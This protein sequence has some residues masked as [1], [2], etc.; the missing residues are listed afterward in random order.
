MDKISIV[1]VCY[2][3]QD[4]IR[5][6][7]DSVLA[8]TYPHIEYVL[9]DGGSTDNTSKIVRQ[10]LEKFEEKGIDNILL[11]GSDQGIYDAMNIAIDA[12]T[13]EWILFLNAGDTFYNQYVLEEI[14]TGFSYKATVL[15]GNL[16]VGLSFGRTFITK[17]NH[18][19]LLDY[20]SVQHQ[21]SFIKTSVLK[22]FKYDT[23]YEICADYELFVKLLYNKYEFKYINK[24]ISEFKMGGASSK[25]FDLVDNERNR[26][27]I[28]YNKNHAKIVN[29]HNLLW[30]I[31]SSLRNKIPIIGEIALIKK[32]LIRSN[33][34]E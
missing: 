14:F 29:S 8:Q 19:D 16:I 31:K 32:E 26:I 18:N 6:T 9:K 15:Y 4:V 23:S 27:K 25:H 20:I 17:A 3:A 28:T 11:E 12:C 21:A 10:Y 13:G 30:K 33:N 34:R 22:E 7:M 24:I 2:N 5:S 1:T